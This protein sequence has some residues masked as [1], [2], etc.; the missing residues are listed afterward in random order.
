MLFI[1]TNSKKSGNF[2][3]D[4]ERAANTGIALLWCTFIEILLK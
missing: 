4:I 2:S 1:R 3:A